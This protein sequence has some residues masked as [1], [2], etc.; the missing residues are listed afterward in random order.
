MTDALT[1]RCR[2][3]VDAVSAAFTLIARHAASSTTKDLIDMNRRLHALGEGDEKS[4]RRTLESLNNLAGTP[5]LLALRLVTIKLTQS[6][7]RICSTEVTAHDLR[8]AALDLH[9]LALEAESLR[10]MDVA[11]KLAVTIEALLDQIKGYR[12]TASTDSLH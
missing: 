8:V 9:H 2:L 10:A 3:A 12:P 1:Y 4:L 11:V 7:P 6:L 5:Q